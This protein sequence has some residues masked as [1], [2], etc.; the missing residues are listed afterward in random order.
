MRKSVQ[1]W[2]WK[3]WNRGEKN[4]IYFKHIKFVVARTVFVR[5]NFLTEWEIIQA[6]RRASPPTRRTLW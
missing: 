2:D 4:K 3:H 1:S 6:G 5:S